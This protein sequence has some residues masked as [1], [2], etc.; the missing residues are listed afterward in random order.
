MNRR[1]TSPPKFYLQ[2][3]RLPA[4]SVASTVLL[5]LSLTLA[6]LAGYVDAANTEYDVING[7]TDLTA[8]ATYTTGGTAGTG[9]GGTTAT[10]ADGHERRDL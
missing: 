1:S 8:P 5:L 4:P 10:G 6:S 7:Q 3:P 9:A 2:V